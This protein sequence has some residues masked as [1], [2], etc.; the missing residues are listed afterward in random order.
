MFDN[1]DN[2]VKIN[3]LFGSA[4][5]GVSNTIFVHCCK[6]IKIVVHLNALEAVI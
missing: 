2:L 5:G 1:E 4:A 3:C 6:N